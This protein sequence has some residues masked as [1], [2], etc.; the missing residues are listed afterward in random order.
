MIGI[1]DPD[2]SE[3]PVFAAELLGQIRASAVGQREDRR[4]KLVVC[5]GH[6]NWVLAQKTTLDESRQPAAAVRPEAGHQSLAEA[7]LPGAVL[8]G[9]VP[10]GA[11]HRVA[12]SPLLAA[13]L[14]AAALPAAPLLAAALP[15]VARLAGDT[16]PVAVLGLH[17]VA[18][19]PIL[20]VP[21]VAPFAQPP[22]IAEPGHVG[23]R[24]RAARPHGQPAALA[25]AAAGS[26]TS[27]RNRCS[28]R[29]AYRPSS[30]RSS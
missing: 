3:V 14:P 20:L 25:M 19:R 7:V 24:R 27:S 2:R 8:P 18:D 23:S 11:V 5:A 28:A 4:R 16:H 1:W 30:T 6:S 12:G 29:W 13:A 10:P 21:S 26:S 22:T 9:A 15:A 17:P